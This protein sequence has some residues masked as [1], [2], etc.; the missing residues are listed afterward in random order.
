VI[1]FVVVL[2]LLAAATLYAQWRDAGSGGPAQWT[3]GLVIV[4]ALCAAVVLVVGLSLGWLTS[5][6]ACS[7]DGGAPYAAP[8]SGYGRYCGAQGYS[9]AFGLPLIPVL[10][11]AGV[12]ARRG[13]W[14]FLAIGVL[15][16]AGLAASPL[17]AG[18]ALSDRCSDE[19][20]NREWR[21]AQP[22]D[23]QQLRSDCQH[24]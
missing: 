24:Y 14:R 7:G 3:S 22:G 13:R 23:V 17:L 19:A 5:A 21:S 11:G 20:A 15:V 12:V 10:L 18:W 2:A 16:A 4:A 8:A 9:I 1:A 6:V